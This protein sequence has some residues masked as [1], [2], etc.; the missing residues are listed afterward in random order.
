MGR[1]EDE[2][3]VVSASELFAVRYATRTMRRAD[4]FYR[5]SVYGEPDAPM[6]IDYFFWV[7]RA[8]S[9]TVLID[10]GFDPDE[11]ARRGRTVLADPIDALTDLAV[12]PEEV[13]AIVVSHFHYDHIGNLGRFP[14]ATLHTS[15]AELDFWTGPLAEKSQ[16]AEP[17][18]PSE[19]AVVAGAAHTGRVQLVEDRAELGAG[20]ELR[21]V[22]GHTPGQ[23]VVLH[24][25]TRLVL[26]SDALHFYEEMERDMPFA[27]LSD[28]AATYRAYDALREL[29]RDGWGVVAGHDPAVA[30]RFGAAGTASRVIALS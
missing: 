17:T 15:R 7:L 14:N 21:V 23:L 3:R 24:A 20:L 9:G 19:I 2:R 22:G 13:S 4:A 8:P 18:V 6:T 28:L 25:G 10:C 12:R 5:Y 26:A 1:R 16:Y 29:E 11:G 27:I 30:E